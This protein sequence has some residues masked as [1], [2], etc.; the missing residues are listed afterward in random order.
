M[1][2]GLK[3]YQLNNKTMESMNLTLDVCFSLLKIYLKRFLAFTYEFACNSGLKKPILF[4]NQLDE[5]QMKYFFEIS[6]K[7]L[8]FLEYLLLRI[9][10]FWTIYAMI[11]EHW[12]STIQLTKKNLCVLHQWFEK[13]SGFDYFFN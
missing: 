6:F 7:I 5:L 11:N 3:S 9:A 13:L 1:T 12:Y 2:N 8:I 10:G 4:T